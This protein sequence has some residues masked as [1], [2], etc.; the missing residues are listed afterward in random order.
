MP[1]VIIGPPPICRHPDHQ[2]LH[3]AL[4]QA[5]FFCGVKKYLPSVV[6]ID[7]PLHLKMLEVSEEKA[8][9]LIDI[10]EH[11][12]TRMEAVMAYESQFG[13]SENSTPT[14]INSGFVE[15]LERRYREC[16]ERI[17]VRYAE[18]FL[19]TQP[20]EINLPIDLVK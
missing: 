17:G 15:S 9:L 11:W 20:P 19:C 8:D 7:R 4:K 2:A 16:G 13:V 12:E 10:S 6:A 18:P 1:K 14:F 5:H 3:D